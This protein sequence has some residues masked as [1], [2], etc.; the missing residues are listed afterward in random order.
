M[1]IGE[2]HH[3]LDNKGRLIIP[4]KYR[5]ELGNTFVITRGIEKCLYVYPID[6]WNKIV[7]KLETLPFTRKNA[8][9]FNRF[10]LSGAI[11]AE[12]DNTGRVT[13]SSPLLSYA[14]ISKDCVIVGSG[15]RIEIFSLDLWNEFMNSAEKNMS[16][17]A[18]GLFGDTYE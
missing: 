18:E 9:E 8:R 10:F 12:F 1:F 13:I 11:E 4:A 5:Q 2:Y 16:D 7:E 3:N 15:D 17:I 6:T 14:S